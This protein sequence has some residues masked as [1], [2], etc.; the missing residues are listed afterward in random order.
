MLNLRDGSAVE[1][2]L[3][4]ASDVIMNIVKAHPQTMSKVDKSQSSEV[5]KVWYLC[6]I[7]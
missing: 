3:V 1:L 6:F 5:Q 4:V 7:F 2:N